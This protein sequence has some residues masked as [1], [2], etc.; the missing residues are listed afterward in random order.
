MVIC[1][2]ASLG[3]C[4]RCFVRLRIVFFTKYRRINKISGGWRTETCVRRGFQ[5]C[6]DG[7][8]WQFS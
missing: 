8:C 1:L 2:L 4:F 6:G 3:D 5:V 7:V